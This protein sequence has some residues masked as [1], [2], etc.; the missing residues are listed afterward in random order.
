[1]LGSGWPELPSQ[2]QQSLV[3][4][5]LPALAGKLKVDMPPEGRHHR[6]LEDL[7][8]EEIRRRGRLLN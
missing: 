1:M 7:M 8:A 5:M 3:A 6:F 4:K 2:Q